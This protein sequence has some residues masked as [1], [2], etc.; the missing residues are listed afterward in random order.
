MWKNIVY[1]I[2]AVLVFL[3]VAVLLLGAPFLGVAA[4]M[5]GFPE[6][7]SGIVLLGLVLLFVGMWFRSKR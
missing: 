7:L 5:S 4:A 2:G 6:V 3:G 1:I